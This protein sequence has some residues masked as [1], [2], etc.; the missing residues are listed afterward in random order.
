MR[1]ILYSSFFQLTSIYALLVAAMYF[2][3]IS[4]YALH[5]QIFALIIA[6]IGAVVISY[7]KDLIISKKIHM[8][9]F[10]LAILVLITLRVIPYIGND[11]PL[12]YDAGIYKYA[13]EH[14]LEKND[15]W[16]VTG[17]TMEPGFLYVMEV[18]KLFFS[19]DFIIKGIFIASIVLLGVALYYCAGVYFGKTAAI[20][21]LLFY[22]VS[23]TQFLTF[24]LMYFR[25][26]LGLSLMLFSITFLKKYE[27]S[28]EKKY[29]YLFILFAALLGAIHRPT[30]Y[31]FGLSYI[32]YALIKP[33]NGKYCDIKELGL[34][35]LYGL[36]ILALA[37]SFY[38][39]RFWPAI[40]TII[41]PVANSFLEAGESPGTFISFTQYQF[42][43]LAYLA[44]A[45]LG[46]FFTLK[47][48]KL[49]FLV[50]WAIVNAIIVYLQFFFFNRF[51]IHLDLV[52]IM[53]AGLGF[54]LIIQE[55]KWL[56]VGI[57]AILCIS[58]A[59]M[60]TQESL[61]T[62]PQF[63][64]PGDISLIKEL[65]AVTEPNATIMAFSKEYSPWI[66]A[67]SNRT[68]IA[69]G[70]F[71]ENKW[72]LS[73]WNTFWYN[74]TEENT[75]KLMEKYDTTRPIYLYTGTKSFNNSCF[76]Q[77]LEENGKK[78]YN[79]VC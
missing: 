68:V 34:Y 17:P 11:I 25:N 79:Y 31:I 67:Y 38:I 45:A 26:I 35:V 58:S 55:K 48:G 3:F 77:F 27:S 51:I 61:R 39:G 6:V 24:T 18:F 76:T 16:I 23:V 7:E 12:G 4:R 72:N 15:R 60:V 22:S 32:F 62:K 65:G 75:I 8:L 40:T 20:I 28:N 42:L 41:K 74:S 64:T 1:R 19:A 69:P 5:F 9:L 49:S 10:L 52:L 2:G 33:F 63:I 44:F 36:V 70:L 78:V 56:G 29:L 43:S 53:F 57:L 30:F 14:G 46:L 54:S 47:K 37:L 21:A 50:I 13:I 71:D 59:Y 73:E 66:L